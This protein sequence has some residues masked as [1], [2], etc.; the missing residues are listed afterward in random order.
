MQC[1]GQEMRTRVT[2]F[3]YILFI[4]KMLLLTDKIQTI[5][6]I[7]FILFLPVYG[8]LYDKTTE[9]QIHQ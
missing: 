7:A 3:L 4:T 1:P 5:L 6:D 9:S 2:N 8:E